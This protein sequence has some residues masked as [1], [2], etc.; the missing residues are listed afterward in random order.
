MPN[1]I[2]RLLYSSVPIFFEYVECEY[3]ISTED[4]QGNGKKDNRICQR[5]DK[6]QDIGTK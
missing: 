6:C 3:D 5:A 2:T 1:A 4:A